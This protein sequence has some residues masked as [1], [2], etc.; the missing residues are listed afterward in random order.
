MNFNRVGT[1]IFTIRFGGYFPLFVETPMYRKQPGFFSSLWILCYPNIIAM[2]KSRV[3]LV[4]NS[5]HLLMTESLFHG[6]INPYY[7][8][9]E[10]PLLY[11]NH[12]SWSTRS[13]ILKHPRIIQGGCCPN[14]THP[15]LQSPRWLISDSRLMPLEMAQPTKW[16]LALPEFLTWLSHLKMDGWNTICLFLLGPFGIFSGD[17]SC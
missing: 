5:S 10:H 3:L 8:V 9:D 14:Q 11:G 17:M 13:H 7:W 2:V 4:I 15:P 12:G 16:Y 6:Y 1:I